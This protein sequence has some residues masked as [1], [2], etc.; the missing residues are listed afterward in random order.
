M[1]MLSVIEVLFAL[2]LVGAG[3]WWIS[4]KRYERK[5]KW[6]PKVP[7]HPIFGN[8]L[9]FAKT[10]D[11]LKVLSSYL[12]QCNGLCSVDLIVKKKIVI[13]DLKLL[14]LL[15]TSTNEFLNK[16]VEYKFLQRWLGDGLLT[17]KDERWRKSR[18]II[19]PAFHFYILRQFVSI[20]ETNADTM[21]KL[22]EKEVGK[23]SVDIYTYVT[24]CTLDIICETSMGV[25]INAQTNGQSD[26]VFAVKEMCRIT[27]DRGFSAMKRLDL[28]YALTKDYYKE[29]R[30]VK[31][32]HSYTESVIRARKKSLL[33]DHSKNDVQT[34][35]KL[36]N[37]YG[38]ELGAKKKMAFLDL[39]LQA[40]L[41]GEPLPD[42]YIREEVDTLM[43]EG[44][45][46]TGAAISFALFCLAENLEVQAQAVEEQRTIFGKDSNR[47]VTFDDIQAM[48]YLELV[49]KETLRI[50][51]SVPFYARNSVRD[52]EYKDG[53]I[54][55]KGTS[56]VIYAYGV[57]NN[58]EIFPNPEKFDPM[59]FEN[60]EK[61]SPFAY[62]PF[63]AGPRNCIGQKFAVHEMKAVISKVL[64]NFELLPAFPRHKPLLAAESVL[65]SA[66]GI[67]VQLKP[68]K[69]D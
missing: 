44:H 17:A 64:R 25:K 16:S 5:L 59:R 61:T 49:I 12:K 18:K 48:K 63:S 2:V 39:L 7:G 53:Q 58:P 38:E 52:I 10:T 14:E 19:T 67:K 37:V 46:T 24:L 23:D 33:S 31:T 60:M 36:K 43:F 3:Y 62:L 69:W 55:P 29:L 32:L 6:I 1:T 50:Y 20:Y 34:E 42:L 35:E 27:V 47:A 9:D 54:I 8:V 68:R 13:S 22:L 30:Y 65:K 4:K 40:R 57:N 66:N 28:L 26:Y 41:D 21:I 15:L 45:D 11:T 56:L 51:P